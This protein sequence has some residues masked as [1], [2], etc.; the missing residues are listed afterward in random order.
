[1][2]DRARVLTVVLDDAYRIEDDLKSL[3]NAISML[4]HVI[5]VTPQLADHRDYMAIETARYRLRGRVLAALEE[6]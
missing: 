5:S 3:T 6:D 4:K 1:M 2:S